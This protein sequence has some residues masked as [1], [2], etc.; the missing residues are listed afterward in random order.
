MPPGRRPVASVF[1]SPEV[2]DLCELSA[3]S[4]RRDSRTQSRI[5]GMLGVFSFTS[6]LSREVTLTQEQIRPNTESPNQKHFNSRFSGEVG[7]RTR[8]HG[9]DTVPQ[10]CSVQREENGK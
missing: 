7:V 5:T 8:G 1:L 9:V 6:A 3:H 4:C 10:E 2:E